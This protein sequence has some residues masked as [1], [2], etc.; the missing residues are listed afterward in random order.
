MK[1]MERKCNRKPIFIEDKC[2][3]KKKKKKG[4]EEKKNNSIKNSY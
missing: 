4:Q 3:P 2:P 1:T